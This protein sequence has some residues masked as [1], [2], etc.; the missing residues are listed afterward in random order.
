MI[1]STDLV[2]ALPGIMG[3][4][5]TRND[6]PVWVPSAGAV[7][8]AVRT[9]GRSL[10][11]LQLQAGIGDAHPDDGVAPGELMPDLHVIPGIW[12]PV[13]GYDSLVRRLHPPRP[14]EVETLDTIGDD[15][16]YGDATVALAGAIGHDPPMDTNTVRRVVDRHGHLQANPWRW[17][18]SR[19]RSPPPPYAAGPARRSR[20]GSLCPT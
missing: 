10:T 19:K 3:S 7:L 11:H 2:V 20:S 15:N 17:T 9:L 5:L 1:A 6:E 8:R 13:T 4:T 12:T 14:R 18:N 16:D